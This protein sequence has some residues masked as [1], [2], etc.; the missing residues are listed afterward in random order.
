MISQK[1]VGLLK[2]TTSENET[3]QRII[4]QKPITY[5]VIFPKKQ[6]PKVKQL[7]YNGKEICSGRVDKFPS[8]ILTRLESVFY[9]ELAAPSSIDKLDKSIEQSEK[10]N[11]IDLI[12]NQHRT[13]TIPPI[14]YIFSRPDKKSA[15]TTTTATE[16]PVQT[17][18]ATVKTAN[19]GKSTKDNQDL[20]KMKKFL[21]LMLKKMEEDEDFNL[22]AF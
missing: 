4:E 20:N 5:M 17:T 3:N 21:K 10:N 7:L 1:D 18:P 8:V 15:P 14:P 11:S 6:L 12:N 16:L 22:E 9:S 2:L 19:L 13:F